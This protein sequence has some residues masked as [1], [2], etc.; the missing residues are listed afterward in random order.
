MGP[1]DAYLGEQ[2]EPADLE[3]PDEQAADVEELIEVVDVEADEQNDVNHAN[4]VNDADANVKAEGLGDR[5]DPD[6]EASDMDESVDDI[7]EQVEVQAPGHQQL[8]HVGDVD[9]W[10]KP[11]NEPF[12]SQDS[13]GK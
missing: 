5:E 8:L 2:D 13:D 3:D 10:L 11:L 7:V 1:E 9:V 4:D 12:G 6:E